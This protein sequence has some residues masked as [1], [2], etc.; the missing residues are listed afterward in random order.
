MWFDKIGSQGWEGMDIDDFPGIA[1]LMLLLDAVIDRLSR[2]N[3][4]DFVVI[5]TGIR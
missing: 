4:A 3:Q 2:A 5:R 1:S